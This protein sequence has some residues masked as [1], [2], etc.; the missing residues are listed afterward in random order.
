MQSDMTGQSLHNMSFSPETPQTPRPTLTRLNPTEGPLSGNIQ[1]DI[2]GTGFRSDIRVFFG[3][4]LASINVWNE[5]ALVAMVP[6]GSMPGPVEVTVQDPTEAHGFFHAQ[7]RRHPLYFKYIDDQEP[8]IWELFGKAMFEKQYGHVDVNQARA[9]LGGNNGMGYGYGGPSMQMNYPQMQQMQQ[10]QNRTL[11]AARAVGNTEDT[12]LQLL[13]VIDL[14]DSPYAANFDI[15]FRN[16]GNTMLALAS[17]LGYTRLVA[18]LVARGATVDT[19]D[20]CGY[21]PLMIAAMRGHQQIVRLLARRGA[22]PTI[23]NRVGFTAADIAKSSDITAVLQQ[24]AQHVRQRSVGATPLFRSRANSI[25]FADSRYIHAS[26]SQ[27]SDASLVTV[28]DDSEAIEEVD[29]LPVRADGACAS[30]RRGSMAHQMSRRSSRRPSANIELPMQLSK[31]QAA[32]MMSPMAAMTAW[33]NQL[34]AQMNRLQQS[35]SDMQFAMPNVSEYQMV[36]R[37]SSMIPF[38]ATTPPPPYEEKDPA[39]IKGMSRNEKAGI[40]AAAA[41]AALDDTC[42]QKFGP[43]GTV[44]TTATAAACP[45]T[46]TVENGKI[47]VDRDIQV[48]IGKQAI[49]KEQQV[50]LRLAHQ[51]RLKSGRSD[52]KV[53]VIWVCSATIVVPLW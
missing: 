45:Q 19:R 24:T 16:T 33:H 18:G 1:V 26:T 49:S 13:N 7:S 25:V 3:D 31:E 46:R 9:M 42:E 15:R 51:A 35:V 52:W 28:S 37:F 48:H 5:G 21:T 8:A 14:D 11:T 32:M 12:L 47:M 22:D 10:R 17:G 44:T 6:A 27:S 43:V 34:L 41:E 39:K 23:R 4:K 29:E 30:S 36:R 40:L 38:S 50:K 53:W 2:H 20:K